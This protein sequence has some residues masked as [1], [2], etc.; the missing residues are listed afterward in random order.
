MDREVQVKSFVGN[1]LTVCSPKWARDGKV[2]TDSLLQGYTITEVNHA[3][4]TITLNPNGAFTFSGDILILNKPEFFV[5][6]P[7][8]TN[9]EWERFSSNEKTKVPF[10]WMV[11]PTNEHFGSENESIERRS[12]LVIVLLDS[13]NIVQWDTKATHSNR[14]QALYNM[15]EEFI[16]TI[17]RNKLFFS[18]TMTHDVMNFTKFGKETSQ[19]MENNVIDANLTGIDLRVTVDI[20]KKECC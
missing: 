9:V 12:D 4:S 5:G 10:I 20:Y 6:T 13:N 15:V 7:I 1:V 16:A 19:G 8:A 18:E 17:Q 14:L 2:V 3:D 11:E